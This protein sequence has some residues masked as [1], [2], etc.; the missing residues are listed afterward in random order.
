M[1]ITQVQKLF[2]EALAGE[3]LSFKEML[4]HLDA[5]IDGINATLP[6]HRDNGTPRQLHGGLCTDAQP[7]ICGKERGS[8]PVDHRHRRKENDL[9]DLQ[10]GFG[11]TQDVQH[12]RRVRCRG[13]FFLGYAVR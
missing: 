7:D 11:R 4:P 5:A 3:T 1:L 8:W 12:D 13:R 9:R 6:G 2:N 10:E